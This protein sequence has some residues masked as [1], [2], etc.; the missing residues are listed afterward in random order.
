[1]G[2]RFNRLPDGEQ[3][4]LR[5][6]QIGFVFQFPSLIPALSAFEN[7]LLPT[8]FTRGPHNGREKRAVEL[9][10][11]V[12]LCEKLESQPRQLSAGQQQRVVI[13]RAMINQ[14][15]LLLADEPTSDLDEQTELE[16][17]RLFKDIH[18]KDRPDH[19]D[20]HPY[21]PAGAVWHPRDRDGRR[22]HP[23]GD[24]GAI[25]RVNDLCPLCTLGA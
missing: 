19:R 22:R 21:Q 1:M 13:A 15:R 10:E 17:I 4:R 5:A 9:L 7:V 20:G 23:P 25:Q 6:E 11:L 14:P 3:A 24:S 12:G 2:A 16:I 18:T 8:G